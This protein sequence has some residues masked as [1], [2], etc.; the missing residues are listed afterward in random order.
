MVQEAKMIPRILRDVSDG[1]LVL[2]KQGTV[3]FLNPQGEKLL[4]FGP[5]AV[6]RKYAAI[7]LAKNQKGNDSFHQFLLDSL[8][9]EENVHKGEI[10]Y[11][12]AD[13]TKIHLRMT[14][15]FLFD[16]SG[17]VYEG[18]VIQFSDVTELVRLRVKQSDS[19]TVFV[20]SI[21]YV[22]S[23]VFVC[24]FWELFG[25]PISEHF[26]TWGVQLLGV[27]VFFIALKKTSFT[28]QDI[29]LGF[30]N[31]LPAI[32][33]DSIIAAAGVVLL[34]GLKY[35]IVTFVP[36][37]FPEGTPFFNFNFTWSE[38]IYPVVVVLQEFLTRSVMH[39]NLRRVISG[40]NKEWMAIVV[41]SLLFGV[42]HIYM[43]VFFMVGAAILLGALGMLYRKQGT[44][45]GLCIPH[46]VL[47]TTLTVL[48]L[49]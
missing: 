26:L 11:T 19:S 38:W 31:I 15:S 41:S 13:G 43:G 4:G 29:G 42:L 22:C 28:I 37:F 17:T 1:V 48:G 33:V 2:D 36:G 35:L 18:V 21:L 46:Y 3:L 12:Q 14:T 20:L 10:V 34:I 40:P 27:G 8:Y 16:E 32:K 47:G 44:I 45:W 23:W 6:G 7:M 25:R 5:D 9:D 24:V 30:K 39:E 49:F